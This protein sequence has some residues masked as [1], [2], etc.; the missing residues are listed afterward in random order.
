MEMLVS[1]NLKILYFRNIGL[2]VKVSEIEQANE[3]IIDLMM[4][5]NFFETLKF[6]EGIEE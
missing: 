6:I 4:V 5:E 3:E 1:H 2:K